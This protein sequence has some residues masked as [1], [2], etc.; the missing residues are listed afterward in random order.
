MF[1]NIEWRKWKFDRG[2]KSKE[3]SKVKIEIREKEN[4]T[5]RR[6]KEEK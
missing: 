5:G 6:K 4:N 2:E 3:K 1:W